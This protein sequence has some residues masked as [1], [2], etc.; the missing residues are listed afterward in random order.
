M[1]ENLSGEADGR[2][3][4]VSSDRMVAADILQFHPEIEAKLKEINGQGWSYLFIETVASTRAI[5]TLN[6]AK[7]KIV[8]IPTYRPN[9][10]EENR[11]EFEIG[12]E[13][14]RADS[15]PEVKEFRINICSKSFPRAVTLD[16]ASG[17]VSYVH[18]PFWKW[19]RGDEKDET[20]LNEAREVYEILRWLLDVKKY[21]LEQALDMRRYEELARLFNKNY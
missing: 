21:R 8:P 6:K 1:S 17:V 16:L 13:V 12:T 5:I 19:Q 15:I 4:L 11:I 18:D 2:I 20:K 10:P 3:E 14:P 7:F 9:S